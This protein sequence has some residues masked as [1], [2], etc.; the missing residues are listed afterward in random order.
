MYLTTATFLLCQIN[1]ALGHLFGGFIGKRQ[2]Q[3][4]VCFYS[5][6]KK[7]SDTICNRTRFPDPAP[8]N[9]KHT[10]RRGERRRV[11]RR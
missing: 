4:V 3:N 8:A 5:L 2:K 10:R 1:N 7:I 11:A 9:T 6:F